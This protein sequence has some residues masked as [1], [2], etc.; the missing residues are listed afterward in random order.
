MKDKKR[1][2]NIQIIEVP[3]GGIKEQGGE[4]VLKR[5]IK[6]VLELNKKEP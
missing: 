4:A 2:F 5:I 1:S 6:N 3:E